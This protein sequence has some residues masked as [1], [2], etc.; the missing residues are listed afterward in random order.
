MSDMNVRLKL[1]DR[2]IGPSSLGKDMIEFEECV[3]GIEMEDLCSTWL[4]FTWTQKNVE[5]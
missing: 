3:N 5:S 2:T 4:H 1:E